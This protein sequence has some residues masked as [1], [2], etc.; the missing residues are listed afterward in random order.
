[1][2]ILLLL[3]CLLCQVSLLSQAT[4]KSRQKYMEAG[5]IL[6]VT[7]YS[8]DIAQKNIHLSETK[9]GYGV[10]ARHFFSNKFSV[11]AHLYAGTLSGDDANSKDPNT[12]RRSF[13][14]TTNFAEVG[15]SGEWH[16]LGKNRYSS[17]GIH[18]RFLS[19]YLY[20]GIGGTF[21]NAKVVYYGT[22]EDRNEFIKTPFPEVGQRQK[23]LIA[24]MGVGL[25]YELNEA[26]VLGA[27]LGWRP[28]FS[29]DI[30]GVRLNGNPEKN[31][32]YYF[33]GATLAF[34]F[35]KTKSPR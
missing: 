29:D 11:K 31:D 4:F 30:D 35:G 20:L 15:I 8:G 7:N 1:M 5:F 25:R 18:Q 23:F 13:R 34:I 16:M 14:F 22:P 17:T 10:F 32:W 24:P 28:V 12:K 2:K 6:G 33:G 26:L 19:P 27:E 3:L 21:S 9:L